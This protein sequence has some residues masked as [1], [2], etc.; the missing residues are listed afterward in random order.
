MD[1]TARKQAKRSRAQARLVNSSSLVARNDGKENEGLPVEM[2]RDLAAEHLRRP[3]GRVVVHEGAA[4]LHRVLH[5]GKRRRLACVFVVLA[6]QGQRHAV[7]GRHDDA[8]RPDL[9][10]ELDRRAGRERLLLVVGMPGAVRPRELRIELAVRGAQPSLPDW[11][12]RIERALEHDLPA[13]R[14]EHAQQDRKS[15]RLNSSHS[16]ISYAVFCLKK[17]KIISVQHWTSSRTLDSLIFSHHISPTP[18]LFLT[19]IPVKLYSSLS[20][21]FARHEAPSH[22]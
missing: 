16:Q 22:L 7:A 6:A 2:Q 14:V 8:G 13:L 3:V 10:V 12:M 21:S 4:A 9:D 5:V 15:T 11:R 19:T 18:D 17:K 1:R 20:Q